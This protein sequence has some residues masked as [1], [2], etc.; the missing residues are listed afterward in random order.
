MGVTSNRVDVRHAAARAERGART[1]RRTAAGAV[2]ARRT[3]AGAT[4]RRGVARRHPQRRPRLRVRVLGRRSRRRRAPSL[5]RGASDRR[6][7]HRRRAS[8]RQRAIGTRRHRGRQPERTHPFGTGRDH[9]GRRPT[10]KRR[11]D[12]RQRTGPPT[13]RFH[14]RRRCGRGR[15]PEINLVRGLARVDTVE[16]DDGSC[17]VVLV[18]G[19]APGITSDRDTIERLQHLGQERPHAPVRVYVEGRPRQRLLARVADVPGYG[20]TPAHRAPIGADGVHADEL[21]LTSALVTV[22]IDP[23]TGTFSLDGHTGCGRLVDG[24]DAGDT[25]NY[26]A[27]AGD[28]IV[29]APTEL[30]TTVVE[31]GPLR[32]R[33]RLDARYRWPQRVDA[34]GHRIGCHD[35]AVTTMLELRADSPL[36][37]VSVTFDNQCD[38]HRLRVHFPLLTPATSFRGR[39][40]VRDGVARAGGRGWPERAGAGHVSVTTLRARRRRHRG[41]R[42]SQRVRVDRHRRRSRQRARDDAVARQS[43]SVAWPDDDAHRTGRTGDRAARLAGARPVS[44]GATPSPLPTSIRTQPSTTPSC[45]CSSPAGPASARVHSRHQVLAVDGA[46]V[47]SVRR[48]GG[49]LSVRL[50]NPRPDRTSRQCGARRL[51]RRSARPS[52]R[53]DRRFV[54]DATVADLHRRPVRRR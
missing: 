54:H 5:R 7:P 11:P 51:G 32:A 31:Q 1:A 27:P 35:V 13:P 15:A 39:V 45:H 30:T 52:H 42:R 29:D 18:T 44:R 9:G 37:R 21:S 19:A 23:A 36:V 47:A 22:Q 49:Q 4:A 50:F 20:W 53:G 46:E 2:R 25:Y 26:C 41:A 40:R 14:R 28:L 6:C 10:A 48:V 33:L 3:L 24:G 12:P 38:D 43:L 16:R 34:D 17:D 8:F